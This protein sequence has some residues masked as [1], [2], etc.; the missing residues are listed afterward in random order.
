[1]KI[2]IDTF[3]WFKIDLLVSTSYIDL[4]ALYQELELCITHDVLEELQNRKIKSCQISKLQVYPIGN[5]RIYDDA[6]TQDFDKA[7][8]SL[9]SNGSRNSDILL[10]SED[11]PLLELGKSYRFDCIQLIDFCRI[12]TSL[13]ILTKRKLFQVNREL[14]RLGNISKKK[15]REMKQH[16]QQMK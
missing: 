12:L 11:Q 6:I 8:A 16:L 2:F 14:R 10:V 5:K 13:N 15:E 1:M 3:S 4:A 7:D 9:L